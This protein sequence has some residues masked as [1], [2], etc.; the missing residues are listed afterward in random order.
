MSDT[1]RVSMLHPQ[2]SL[3]LWIYTIRL[4]TQYV[5]TYTIIICIIKLILF[6]LIARVIAQIIYCYQ[7]EVQYSPD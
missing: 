7:N 3:A 6:I 5:G 1:V 4:Y 2:I